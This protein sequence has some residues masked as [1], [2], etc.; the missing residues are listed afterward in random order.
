[1]EGSVDEES[2][3][4][5]EEYDDLAMRDG[6]ETGYWSDDEEELKKLTSVCEDLSTTNSMNLSGSGD[7]YLDNL[8]LFLKT[9]REPLWSY[10]SLMSEKNQRLMPVSANTRMRKRSLSIPAMGKH[11]SLVN[12]P[13]LSGAPQR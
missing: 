6:L 4:S 13:I 11:G 9:T 5:D 7:K 1:M 12:G 3:K 8:N 2:T 10:S